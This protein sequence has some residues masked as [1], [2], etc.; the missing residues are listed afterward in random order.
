MLTQ[1]FRTFALS[2]AYSC[3]TQFHTLRSRM[4]LLRERTDL[5]KR[6]LPACCM[7]SYYLI[8]YGL[9]HLIVLT[10][11]RTDLLIG[12]LR[13]RPPFRLGV[14]L[15]QRSPTSVFSAPEHG[16][17][18]PLKRGKLLIHGAL[19]TSLLYTLMV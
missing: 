13:I 16:P 8:S 1:H 4:E 7:L 9:K 3:S 10:T 19:T 5:S 6:W 2:L 18:S 17:R 11:S 12:L 14:A 15:N